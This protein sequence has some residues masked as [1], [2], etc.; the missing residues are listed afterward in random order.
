MVLTG[1]GIQVKSEASGT[2]VLGRRRPELQF[3]LGGTGRVFE[4]KSK[5]YET[6]QPQT[7]T[8][9]WNKFLIFIHWFT[10]LLF[11]YSTVVLNNYIGCFSCFYDQTPDRKQ[12]I[13]GRPY[14]V[15]RFWEGTC[16]S[17]SGRWSNPSSWMHGGRS[18]KLLT[19][20]LRSQEAKMT[21]WK[22]NCV[23]T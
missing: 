15:S 18:V 11:I 23:I 9:N 6:N 19:R 22:L 1:T 3:Q 13:R 4:P 20:I 5:C 14:F 10:S 8:V 7:K 21:C 17:W 16:L 2:G 12:L